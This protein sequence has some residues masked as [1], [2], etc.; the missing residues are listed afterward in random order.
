MDFL[1]EYAL[2]KYLL[3]VG[4]L[5]FYNGLQNFV[6]SMR[7]TGR[8][9]NRT[10]ET[11]PLMSRMMGLWTITSA[12]VRVYTALNINDKALYTVCMWT[13][14]LALFSFTTEVFLY[15]TAK[16]SSPGVWPALLISPVSLWWMINS[17]SF[18]ITK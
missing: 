12:I 9:Y 7:V 5:A 10:N 16:W 18:F 13:F 1:P 17:Y 3:F 14:A 11:T 6:P 2:P 8:I 4:S 15:K